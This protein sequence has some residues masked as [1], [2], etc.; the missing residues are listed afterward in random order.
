MKPVNASCC[1]TETPT[2][3]AKSNYTT[4]SVPIQ[5]CILNDKSQSTVILPS[6]LADGLN[7]NPT[8]PQVIESICYVSVMEPYMIKN[9]IE[10]HEKYFGN[11]T[12][13]FCIIPDQ[14]SKTCGTYDPQRSPWFVAASSRPNDTVIVIDVSVTMGDGGTNFYSAFAKAFDTIQE[15][16]QGK[17]TT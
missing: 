13:S 16:I 14:H 5:I 10:G 12:G 1:D 11:S 3:C 17:L 4:A 15:M 9:F 2:D 6:T 8:D 7:D